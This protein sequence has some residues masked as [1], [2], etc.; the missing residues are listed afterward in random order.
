MRQ[1]QDETL[2]MSTLAPWS[3]RSS[4]EDVQVCGYNVPAGTPIIFAIGVSLTS[5]TQ[6]KDETK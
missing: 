2:R 5:G 1:V 4:D 6:W 3:A